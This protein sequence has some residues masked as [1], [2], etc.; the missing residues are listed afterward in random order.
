MDPSATPREQ[1]AKFRVTDAA[2]CPAFL[3]ALI[4]QGFTVE[5]AREGVEYDT[6]LDTPA[7][8]LVR[9]GLAL[10]LRRTGD[11]VTL[12]IK[13]LAT[14]RG[15]LIQAR[16]DFAVPLAPTTDITHFD[17][18][19]AAIVAAVAG[20]LPSGADPTTPIAHIHQ[21]RCR[22][23]ISSPGAASPVVEW[24]L[25][26]VT[27][28]APGPS[29]NPAPTAAFQELEL[30]WLPTSDPDEFRRLVATVPTG[31][32]FQPLTTSKLERALRSFPGDGAG[33]TPEMDVAEACRHILY[34]QVIAIVV[35]EH[36][37]RR[38]DDPESVHDMRVAIRRA[39]A[40][41]HLFGPYFRK[42]TLR[43]LVAGLRR[44]GRALGA[45][46]D[47]DIALA[48]LARFRKRQ[49]ADRRKGL[50]L[51]RGHLKAE[52]GHAYVALLELL[53]S[54]DHRAWLVD[55]A[56]FCRTPGHGLRKAAPRDHEIPP[57]Q[58][59]H[60]FPGVIFACYLAVRAYEDAFTQAELPPLETYHSLR[61]ACKYLRYSLEFTRHLLG[62]PGEALI[63]QLKL[64]QDHLGELNDASVDSA[65]LEEWMRRR[66]ATD[67]LMAR[68]AALTA[69][70]AALTS[71]FPPL[72][73]HFIAAENRARLGAALAL[74]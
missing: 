58:V 1:E 31:A 60:T 44:L 45:V 29:A 32:A 52:R 48:N 6:Y 20:L 2:A 61:I 25:D 19:P 41:V 63:A 71:T 7:F 36:A 50:K 57:R 30:E 12:G 59:R 55:F 33:V 10:R 74:L 43:P 53:D 70:I 39:R 27:V 35:L 37:V 8:D 3:A 17:T 46:R 26:D 64:L 51:L 23:R 42:R 40:A 69:A 9:C 47:L 13:T 62:E 66:P 49:P 34:Q 16:T 73:A 18:W 65:R 21:V 22:R 68:H 28:F 67:A 15:A 4:Q 38:G 72:Y 56:H 54:H 11:R 14:E 24:S 5:D